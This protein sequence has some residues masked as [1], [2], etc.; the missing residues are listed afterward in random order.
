[1]QMLS[2]SPATLG[3]VTV[4]QGQVASLPFLLQ[5]SESPLLI[6]DFDN[7]AVEQVSGVLATAP[8]DSNQS[9][10]FANNGQI[11][12]LLN[13][14]EDAAEEPIASD[15]KYTP[16]FDPVTGSV[17]TSFSGFDPQDPNDSFDI[18]TGWKAAVDELAAIGTEEVTF[19]VY[20]QVYNGNLQGGA[21]MATVE[22]AIDYANQNDLSVT[23]LPLFE[24]FTGGDAWRGEY[25]PRGAERTR[26]RT[27]Y[28]EFVTELAGIAGIDRFNVGTELNA[29]VNNTANATFFEELIDETR[30][31]LDDA[32][33]TATRIGYS[34]NFD[35]FDN[36]QHELLWSN[37]K[38]DFLGVS[39]YFSVIDPA[40]A[41]L[42]SGT[43]EV[44]ESVIQHMIQ[45][46]TTELDRLE[47]VADANDL[48]VLIQEFGAVQENYTSV[49]P[50]A[51]YPGNFLPNDTP[52]SYQAD[53]AEQ[54]AVYQSLLRALD[55]R[56]D[57]FESVNFWSWEHGADRGE[58]TYEN[59]D[60][61]E[62][63]YINR[64]AIWPGDSGGG[65]AYT[66]FLATQSQ[67][68]D[69]LVDLTIE[70]DLYTTRG[71]GDGGEALTVLV[72][73]ESVLD[74]SFASSDAIQT[75]TL[76]YAGGDA[77]HSVSLEVFGASLTDLDVTI[78]GDAT[79]SSSTFGIDNLSISTMDTPDN[80]QSTIGAVLQTAGR[81][82]VWSTDT[83]GLPIG[84]T[85]VDIL[86]NVE[87]VKTVVGTIGVNVMADP[88]PPQI[89][90]IESLIEFPSG[91]TAT[92]SFQVVS[93]NSV[94]INDVSVTNLTGVEIGSVVFDSGTYAWSF[95]TAGPVTEV[96]T[97]S[98]VA[99]FGNR[100]ELNFTL[101]V[102]NEAPEIQLPAEV[103]GVNRGDTATV[104]F[105]ISDLE[106][107]SIANVRVTDG[108]NQELG[109][110]SA[111]SDGSYDWNLE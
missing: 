86:G 23:V 88:T 15:L 5:A 26:F 55:G 30:L 108:Q 103:F 66:E 3:E 97:V 50:F 85:T 68:N 12:V 83:T 92:Q 11:Q 95:T 58:R 44:A 72:N 37:S 16:G 10:V 57:T 45:R 1:R 56:G 19:A 34:A 59:I 96:L 9:F 71:W 98:A 67:P 52:N 80:V 27:Q 69:G 94:T 64:F 106:S 51:V 28:S 93:N 36:S 7:G 24:V 89:N 40:N 79:T 38:I 87:G 17:I 73:G 109:T 84:N 48:P 13:Q 53:A 32:G 14:G 107:H 29:M 46:W 60:P 91:E 110:V 42:V 31:A 101:V 61:S 25:D 76:G 4:V 6:S 105:E 41:D 39:A 111:K 75:N 22:A 90:D 33:N 81:E 35:A 77:I 2:A 102:T 104:E 74:K 63:R 47:A 43:G 82:F 62:P 49:Y 99:E 21:A 20:R 100:A 65:D 18:L 70:F 78:Q 54:K 8:A